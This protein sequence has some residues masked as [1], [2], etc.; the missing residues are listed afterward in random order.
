MDCKYAVVQSS[1][2]HSFYWI[3]IVHTILP[4]F[5]LPP[6]AP[7]HKKQ[8]QEQKQTV[9]HADK[10][11]PVGCQIFHRIRKIETHIPICAV[12]RMPQRKTD[13]DCEYAVVQSSGR[14]VECYRGKRRDW[15]GPQCG[16]HPSICR[17]EEK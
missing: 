17:R 14:V 2:A 11:N 13:G 9:P 15:T 10:K 7:G 1:G 16:I 4:S 6:T 5:T 8:K 3:S 12:E